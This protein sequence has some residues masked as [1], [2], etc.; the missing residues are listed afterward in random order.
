VITALIGSFMI[1]L[2]KN[3]RKKKLEQFEEKNE[4]EMND[5]KEINENFD[6]LIDEE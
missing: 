4:P 5:M 1:W 2:Q 6:Q 3:Q